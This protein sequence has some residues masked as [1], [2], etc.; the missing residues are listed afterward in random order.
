[1]STSAIQQEVYFERLS[2]GSLPSR[3]YYEIHCAGTT[4]V[5]IKELNDG[6]KTMGRDDNKSIKS[7]RQSLKRRKKKNRI[8]KVDFSSQPREEV[9]SQNE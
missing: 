9:S 1:M 3:T 4:K 8:I 6:W 2:H 5:H 7:Y